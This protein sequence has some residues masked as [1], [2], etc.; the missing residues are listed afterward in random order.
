MLAALSPCSA[1]CNNKV[2]LSSAT[3]SVRDSLAAQWVSELT[4]GS[5]SLRVRF[6]PMGVPWATGQWAFL[7]PLLQVGPASANT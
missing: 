6:Q 7:T 3:P 1:L 2:L 5:L 4:L